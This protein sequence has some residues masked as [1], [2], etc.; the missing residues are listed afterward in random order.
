MVAAMAAGL[1]FCVI[2]Y[3]AQRTA[4]ESDVEVSNP[5]ELGPAI[6]F[7]LLYAAVL[8]VAKVAQHY[9]QDAGVYMASVVAGLTD[10]DAIT[11]SMAEL[12]GAPGGV[13]LSTGAR[14]VVL[15][16]IA[17]TVV[18]GGIALTAGSGTLRR[19]LLPPLLLMLTVSAVAGF[20]LV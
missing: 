1:T 9:F 3:F 10:V 17:N 16:V 15:A 13:S 18:K 2:Y 20:L 6:K 4:Q 12:S 7:G 8:L 19:A 14:A 11:L 5:F